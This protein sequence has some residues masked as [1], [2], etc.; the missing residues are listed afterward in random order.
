MKIPQFLKVGDEVAIVATAK[1]LEKDISEGINTLEK[2][3]LKVKVGKSVHNQH[4]YFAGSDEERIHD[5]QS[6]L[7]DPSIKAI[8]FARGGYGTTRILDQ[9]DFTSYLSQP[10][11]IV[12]F[13]D[14]TSILL[15]SSVLE[16]PSVH[17]PVALTIGRDEVS[18]NK[19]KDL[20]FGELDF[21]IPLLESNHTKEGNC[22]GKVVGGNLSLIYESI[23]SSNEIETDGNI[24]FLEEVSEEMYAVDRMMNKLR[25]SGKLEDISGV[26]IGSFTSISDSQSYFKESVEEL[27]LKYFGHLDIPVA[28]GLEAGHEKRNYPLI[29]GMNCEVILSKNQISIKYIR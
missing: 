15:L 3:G 26:I 13:S 22:S 8:V 12:G 5:L 19:L 6:A 7:D 9:I 14:L 2:W 23:G 17:G 1:R 16:V 18:D 21:D 29:L 20:L 24:L 4:G 11:W 27:L 10:K 28:F 25:R